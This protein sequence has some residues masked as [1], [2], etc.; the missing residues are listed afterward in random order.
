MIPVYVVTHESQ[1]V[2]HAKGDCTKKTCLA[3][4]IAQFH[5]ATFDWMKEQAGMPQ[6]QY[7]NPQDQ[8]ILMEWAISR[9]L[10]SNW[11]TYRKYESLK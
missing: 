9:N 1:W 5:E 4:G 7:E 6:L 11:T 3:N 2:S 8:I 10:G